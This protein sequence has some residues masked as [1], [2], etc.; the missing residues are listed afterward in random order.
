MKTDFAI[1]AYAKVNLSLAINGITQ[2]GYHDLES[3]VTPVSLFDT[4]ELSVSADGVNTVTYADGRTYPNDNAQKALDVLVAECGLPAMSCRITKRIP[5]GV[6]LGGSSADAA[7]IVRAVQKLFDVRVPGSVMLE[8]GSDVPILVKG[9]LRYMR[10]RG[11]VG[12]ELAP[13]EIYMT[14]VHGRA[15]VSTAK[16]FALYDEIGGEGGNVA[17][18]AVRPFNALERAATALA[19]EIAEY[20]RILACAGYANVVMTGAGS[21][22]VGFTDNYQEFTRLHAKA[23]AGAKEHGYDVVRVTN[24]KDYL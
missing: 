23:E 18:Y 16:A 13:R 3:I 1:S 9:G 21:A 10:G 22:F 6:G 19:P 17:D 11:S 20:R 8:C 15:R 5:E 12:E 24:I 7:G 2:D 14:L 4:V